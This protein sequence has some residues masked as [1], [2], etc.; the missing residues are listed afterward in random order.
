MHILISALS[1]FTQ[2][3]GLCRGAA[4]LAKC[5]AA[6]EQVEQI[7]FVL[8][9]WQRQYFEEDFQLNS[10]KIKVLQI[11]IKNTSLKRNLWFMFELPKLVNKLKPNIAHFSFPIP[12]LN[13]LFSVP[14]VSTI[15]DFY[16][17]EKPENFGF[18]NY[19]FNQL[20]TYLAVI[21]SDGIVCVSQET[22]NRLQYY[23]PK[24]Y[25]QGK[26][27]VVYNYVDFE[28]TQPKL[29]IKLNLENRPFILSVAQHRKNKNLHLLIQAYAKLIEEKRDIAPSTQLILVGST[30][31]ET[32]N[33]IELIHTKS[34][35]DRVLLTS[36]IDDEQLCW[37]Y[38]NCQ[39]V[40]CPS[41][42]EGFCLPLAEALYFSSRVVCSD[43]PIFREVGA[44]DCFYFDL[45]DDPV[46]NLSQA[47]IN[48]LKQPRPQLSPDEFRFSKTTAMT[49]Y[50]EFYSSLF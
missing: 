42:T 24:V 15:H 40:V 10:D 26:N 12:F 1:R 4:N 5:L 35:G 38:Q 20:F 2:P 7:T 18:P 30:G 47:I 46:H 17:Y 27:R 32:G 14:V 43:I 39:L 28:N 25:A 41:S 3:T 16:P 44:S 45:D 48:A 19:L 6:S 21:N 36:S 49:Q 9:S 33:L 8:G 31:P 50:L 37:L 22:L 13:F 23:F 11:E 34:L 29:P